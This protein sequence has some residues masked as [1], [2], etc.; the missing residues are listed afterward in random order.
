[1]LGDP[2]E[3]F[4]IN[5][6]CS[7]T[8]SE[9]GSSSSCSGLGSLADYGLEE[10]DN[11]NMEQIPNCDNDASIEDSCGTSSASKTLAK[12]SSLHVTDID[13]DCDDISSV[14]DQMSGKKNP[15]LCDICGEYM[16][17]ELGLKIHK[18]RKHK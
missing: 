6:D 17:G 15:I 4:D 18:S 1:V 13:S 3:D 5:D 14:Q 9:N 11:D 16:N 8:D 7:D 10:E 2:D 12:D